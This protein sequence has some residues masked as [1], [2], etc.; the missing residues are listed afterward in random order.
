VR[1]HGAAD[2]VVDG[3]V[4]HPVLTACLAGLA[5]IVLP[6]SVRAQAFP[7]VT[8]RA[9]SLDV[10]Q[11]PI[12]ASNRTLAMGGVGVATAEAANG[13]ADNPAAPAVVPRGRYGGLI[14]DFTFQLLFPGEG[15]DFDNNGNA[16]GL[17]SP[18]LIAD[19]SLVL[20]WGRW[21][22]GVDDS[23]PDYLAFPDRPGTP[24]RSWAQDTLHVTLGHSALD[25]ALVVGLGLRIGSATLSYLQVNEQ[26]GDAISFRGANAEA[27]AIWRPQTRNLRLGATLA[28][29]VKD[30]HVEQQCDP[31]ACE[32]QILP[33]R[34]RVPWRASIGAAWRFG[35]SPWNVAQAGRFTDERTLL[36]AADLVVT[37]PMTDGYGIGTYLV[38]DQLQPSGRATS[39]SP[40]LGLET[41][42]V[43]GWLRLRAGSYW[44]PTRFVESSGRLH[45]TAGFEARA[46]ALFSGR[47]RIQV[48]GAIDGARSYTNWS[49]SVGLWH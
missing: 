43:P 1:L 11:G 10:F 5:G 7:P 45:G 9:F 49:V 48:N 14:V 29:P 44:E 32:G 23:G 4:S 21:A 12:T 2:L 30:S 36:V 8:N 18:L 25:D 39:L 16:A 17:S 22:L 40:R 15:S 13:I 3:A 41:E 37:G 42:L 31:N 28:L 20:G 35:A 38:S 46:L 47:A 33:G 24:A 19:T 34:V 26:F 27:G 6:A